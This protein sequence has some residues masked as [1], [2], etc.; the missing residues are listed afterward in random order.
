MISHANHPCREK[1]SPPLRILAT[2]R[3]M[4]PTAEKLEA[5]PI[6]VSLILIEEQ[7]PVDNALPIAALASHL[8]NHQQKIALR[9]GIIVAYRHRGISLAFVSWIQS[10]LWVKYFGAGYLISLM[11][12]IDNIVAALFHP[13][14]SHWRKIRHVSA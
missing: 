9:P 5:F 12:S 3:F 6:N 2:V 7:F 4:P 14:T 11:C 1:G 10:N 8:P 13:I